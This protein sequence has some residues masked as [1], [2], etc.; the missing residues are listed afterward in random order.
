MGERAGR[1]EQKYLIG[2]KDYYLLKHMLPRILTLDTN[3]LNGKSY[4]VS[5]IYFDDPFNSAY[6]EKSGWCF[7]T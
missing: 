6:Y 5:S 4:T 2:K 3:N 7:R 1:F